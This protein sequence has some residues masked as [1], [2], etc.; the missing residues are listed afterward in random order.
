MIVR[1]Y[2]KLR[3]SERAVTDAG[4]TSVRMLLADD[5]MGFSFHITT[6]RAGTEHEFH[7]RHHL[8]SVHCISGR[9]AI[10]DLATGESFEIRPGVT[11]ALDQHDRHRIICHEEMVLACVFNPPVT[12]AEVHREDGSYA[13]AD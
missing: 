10:T 3:D 12:G 13:P 9:G 4:W 1:D 11:Y 2:E 5:G 6:I 7:Y 8:E